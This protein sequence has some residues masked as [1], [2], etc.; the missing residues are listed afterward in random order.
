MPMP[1][2]G[3]LASLWVAAAVAAP[4]R[5]ENATIAGA[6]RLISAS[7]MSAGRRRNDTPFGPSPT[8]MLFYTPSGRMAA[9]I[10]YSGRRALTGDR[11]AA[12]PNERAQ[13]FA[14]SFAYSGRYTFLCDRVVHRVEVSTVPNWVGTDMTRT[15]K[16]VGD[17]LILGTP[18]IMRAGAASTYELV[19]ERTN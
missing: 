3:A 1:F 14:T 7:S 15:V 4:Q 18:S 10:S 17:R 13:A 6:W 11:V 12:P 19:W 16:I 9:I 2:L 5:C 8:G